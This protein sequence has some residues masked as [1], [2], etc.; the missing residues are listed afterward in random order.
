MKNL[1]IAALMYYVTA[2]I[3]TYCFIG[4]EF[5]VA[6]GFSVFFALA[7]AAVSSSINGIDTFLRSFRRR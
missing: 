3:I 1:I 6:A 5:I 7:M 4:M 2:V